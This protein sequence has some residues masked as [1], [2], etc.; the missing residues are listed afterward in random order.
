SILKTPVYSSAV[1]HKVTPA[2]HAQTW[3]YHAAT[4]HARMVKTVPIVMGATCV[5]VIT[6]IP[7]SIVNASNQ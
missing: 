1:V 4:I 3:F 2:P 6:S 7:V 5:R